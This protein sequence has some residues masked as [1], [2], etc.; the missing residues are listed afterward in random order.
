[1]TRGEQFAYI[2]TARASLLLWAREQGIPLHGIEFVVPFVHTD[3]SVSIW[4]FYETHDQLQRSGAMQWSERLASH[5]TE[6]LLGLG[7]AASWLPEARFYFDSH[8]NVVRN[9]EG[10][11]FYRLR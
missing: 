8:E 2:E 3:F 11:Y 9:Y 6:L 4:C 5:F 1:M 7:Y 10:S